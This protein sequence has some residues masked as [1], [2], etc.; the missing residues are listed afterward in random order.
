LRIDPTAL[1]ALVALNHAFVSQKQ[2]GMG[3]KRVR[4]YTSRQPKSA[5]AQELL[6][7]VLLANGDR[8]GAREALLAS[9]AADPKYIR[10]D[11]NL[12]RLDVAEGKWD[13]AKARL[14]SVLATEP[15]NPTAR[16]W[17]GDVEATR[18]DTTVAIEHFRKLLETN[19]KN[20]EAL[21]NLAYL[22]L[23]QDSNLDEALKYAQKAA[24]LSPESPDF[25]DTLGW[26]LYRKGLYDASIQHLRRAVSQ[27]PNVVWNYHLAMAYAK[28][29]QTSKAQSTL[30]A[31][32]R[33]DPK[34]PEAQLALAVVR[35]G[36]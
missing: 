24:E 27:K 20:P 31:A 4:E 21:N 16:Q 28:A 14:K 3:L 36:K 11:L 33:Q 29:G 34:V 22:L 18:G 19:P 12:V 23:A 7:F 30:D 10:A 1:G 2:A 6:G 15:E 13:D 5:R 9:K 26:V 32:L 25:A 8:A 35:G 17:L